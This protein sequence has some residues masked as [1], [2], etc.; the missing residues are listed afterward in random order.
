MKT[1]I[2]IL[3]ILAALC[4]LIYLI[5][6]LFVRLLI[7]R[8]DEPSS[9]ERGDESSPLLEPTGADLWE[10]NIPSFAPFRRLPF[11]K[12][13][14]TSHDGI[15]L[16]ADLLRA[17]GKTDVTLL[18]FH[19]YKS[20]PAYDFAAMYDF[21]HAQGYNLVY[22]HMR[23]HG[24]S[25]GKYIGFGALDRYDAA[26]WCE[27][28]AKLFPDTSLFLHGMSMGAASIMQASCLELPDAVCGIISDCGFSSTNEVFRNL[29]GTM[30][31]LP[32]TPFVEIFEFVNRKKAGYGFTEADS[33]ECLKRTKLP[34]LY[35]VGD[36]D[37]FVPLPMAQRIFDA[38]P[39]DKELL[40][41]ENCGHAASF[42][43]NNDKYTQLV[44]SFINK[45]KR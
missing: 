6:C 19:G 18:F 8:E 13:Y 29:I 7:L 1:S 34:L 10:H 12:H 27:Y 43:L 31:H 38:C 9:P 24:E 40:I 4:A 11:E 33:I 20:E 3:I 5:G 42:M 39:N 14:I 32:A 23:S 41:T 21:Y 26:L 44:V 35:F 15:K 16:C 17:D 28:F 25:D 22:V 30:F 37:V 2:I 45:H 36:S